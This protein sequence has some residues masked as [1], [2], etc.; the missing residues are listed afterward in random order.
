MFVRKTNTARAIILKFKIQNDFL[1]KKGIAGPPINL[2]MVQ[3]IKKKKPK[4]SVNGDT[5]HI[6]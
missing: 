6:F 4:K 1:S 3:V 5:K 2:K